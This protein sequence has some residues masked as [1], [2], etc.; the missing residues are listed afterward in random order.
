MVRPSNL[1]RERAA[2]RA[3]GS[4]L[5]KCDVA[6]FYPSLYTHAVGW[7]IT[8]K[9]RLRKNWRNTRLL[10][11]R[12][13][14]ALMG[15]QGRVSQGIPIGPDL[16]LL[17]AEIVLARVDR[18]LRIP[19][20]RAYRWYDDYEL[21]CDTKEEAEN[22]LTRL[23]GHLRA[24]NLRPNVGKTAI[25]RLP[26]PTQE[27]WQ[28]LLSQQSNTAFK[29]PTEMVAFFDAAFSLRAKYPGSP[30]LLYA[31]GLLFKLR[32][33]GTDVGRVAQS[34]ITQALLIEPG[35]AQKGFALIT[36]WNI[37]GY[38]FDRSLFSH[39]INQ[40]VARHRDLGVSSDVCWALAFCLEHSLPLGR[41]ACKVLSSS[42]DDCVA[43]QALDA[44]KRGLLPKGFTTARL[45]SLLSST[46]LD[47]P[48]WLL[49]YEAHHQ[50]FLSETAIAVASNLLFS[51]LLARN[52]TFYRQQLPKY[53]FVIQPGS[54]PEWVVEKWVEFV[55]G[56]TDEAAG[57]PVVQDQEP[58]L[59]L[60]RDG[61]KRVA[62]PTEAAVVTVVDQLLNL[63][64]PRAEAL[65]PAAPTGEA[66]QA[67][68]ATGTVP[69]G[70]PT[71]PTKKP[72]GPAPAPPVVPPEEWTSYS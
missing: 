15:L 39:T 28:V 52:V 55:L 40:M 61:V 42:E 56:K 47:G 41:D 62:P 17:F 19:A 59:E 44:H 10:G 46:S 57:G 7:A 50:G 8:P 30:V 68:Q 64:E 43:L 63:E 32:N 16:S 58:V 29:H 54:A 33:P 1:L 26:I 12:I 34:G 69:I 72:P 70:Q 35:T 65:A 2:S 45:R 37:N 60:L 53:A 9:T 22:L 20:N 48:H 23:V 51:Q 38:P 3:G 25:E 24:F 6:Q 13:D 4:Y 14:D 36:Y 49:A 27:D 21:C 66:S 18:A 11:K 67:S 5:V 71:E 31:L